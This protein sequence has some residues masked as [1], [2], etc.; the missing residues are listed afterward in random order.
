MRPR[1]YR[2]CEAPPGVS[3]GPRSIRVLFDITHP[4][5]AHFFENV[6]HR[7]QRDGHQ[8]LV[9]SRWKDVTTSVLDAAGIDHV[10]VSTHGRGLA[11]MAVE[12]L[13]R[14]ARLLKLAAR[15][16]ADVLVARGGVTIG[17]V[18]AILR[19][20]RVVF[21]DTEHAWLERVLSLPLATCICTG[22][23]YLGDHGARQVRFRAFPVMAYLDPRYYRPDPEPLRRA[24]LDPD[25]PYIVMRTVAWRAAH[26]VGLHSASQETLRRAVQRLS[27]YGRVVISSEAPLPQILRPY[28][29]PVP[30]EHMHDLLAFA[31]L[32]I[33]QGGTMAE[34]AA[35]LGT[36]AI[37]CSPLRMGF[38]LA[39]ERQYGLVSNTN[40][41][42]QGLEVAEQWLRRPDLRRAWEAKRRAA[43]QDSE[44]V[45][46]FQARIIQ[47]A[48]ARRR[49]RAAAHQAPVQTQPGDAGAVREVLWES[50]SGGG[51]RAVTHGRIPEPAPAERQPRRAKAVPLKVVKWLLFAAVLFFVGRALLQQWRAISWDAI[52]FEASFLVLAVASVLLA[53]SLGF[54]LYGLLLGRFCRRPGWLRMM[55]SVWVAQ[56]A[57][58]VPGKVG[59]VVG[60]VVLLRPYDVPGQAVV[61]TLFIIDGI[62]VI[63]GMMLA[64]PLTLWEPV[65][66]IFPNAWLWCIPVIGVGLACLH[67]RVFGSVGNFLLRKFGYRPLAML[68]RVRD[69]F[70][71]VG[72]MLVQY[73]FLGLG[74][75]LMTRSM[76]GAPVSSVPVFI[77]VVV[78]ANIAGFLAF[79]APAG[80]GVQEGL[81]LVLLGPLVGGPVAA[82][83]AVIMRL[84]QTLLEVCL[85]AVGLVLRRL[86]GARAGPSAA[87]EGLSELRGSDLSRP[88]PRRE[89]AR[90]APQR[91]TPR[92]RASAVAAGA[93]GVRILFDLAHPAH[94]HLFKHSILSLREA[95]YETLLVARQK[96]C[97]QQLL[98]EAGWTYHIVPRTGTGF[99]DMSAET[100]KALA[101]IT[102]LAL[103]RRIDLMLGTSVVIG[104][105][106]RLTGSCA[107]VFNED[108][109]AVAPIFTRF[110]YSLADWV[111]TPRLLAHESHGRKHLTYPGYHELAYLHPKR[112]QP[113]PAVRG[114]LGLRPDEKY[115]LVR[116]VALT[117]HHDLGEKGLSPVQ[118]RAVVSLLE[119]YGRVFI[120]AEAAVD[121]DLRPY[122][123]PTSPARMPDVLAFAQLFV[124]DS[125]TMPAE[126]AV[127]GTPALRC[128][129][130]VG[131]LS[132]LE[133]LEHRYGLTQGFRPE[134]FDR[135]LE[136]INV[137]M[138]QPDLKAR[139]QQK[140]QRLLSE[141]VDLTE[142]TLDLIH[143]TLR[144]RRQGNRAPGSPSRG[145]G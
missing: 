40:S 113:D 15:F 100:L 145:S 13:V 33:G 41:L 17:L 117:A 93:Q 16:R 85:A 28:Q 66:A 134:E 43:L 96:D 78:L 74:Y 118:A 27:A 51:D 42:A 137:W 91:P 72:V 38:L 135:L 60:M 53:K 97:L 70:P 82:I 48:G 45:V 24:G 21:D 133:E 12:L 75:W 26:D 95:G 136:Q 19:I 23:G 92:A 123:L 2:A 36:P 87:G 101:L 71:L 116:L 22:T 73:A 114:L 77:C 65:R 84:V 10:R 143:R 83:L 105:A 110:A 4:A 11:G 63:L 121:K 18:G 111:V 37:F 76:T 106:A 57:K 129:T 142:W 31:R 128:S 58:Y 127:L 112:F 139:W 25:G 47:E 29:N 1:K 90:T 49:G 124:G 7:L 126:A 61:S 138:S 39:L 104:P 50:A 98:D 107:I 79:F 125:Q 67:P 59:S 6:I 62:A 56:I 119:R 3:G 120:S 81:L 35:L 88:E 109:F 86:T 8:V 99:L 69:Y 131:R 132:Y 44:D 14:Q 20:P 130:F 52:H 141:C 32:Y 54:L 9:A 94:F 80:L 140:R 30:V 122:L 34:E 46:E 144:R 89:G 5:Q 55:S 115:F 64:I 102:S 103:K 68:P 108:D